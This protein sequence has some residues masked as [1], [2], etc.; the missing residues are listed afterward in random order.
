MERHFRPVVTLTSPKHGRKMLHSKKQSYESHG[1]SALDEQTPSKVILKARPA[2]PFEHE[3]T[4]QEPQ[5]IFA[6]SGKIL[7]VTISYSLLFCGRQVP[8]ASKQVL[9]QFLFWYHYYILQ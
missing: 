9:L 2:L 3:D 4:I 7:S 8:H 1:K 5:D 6:K